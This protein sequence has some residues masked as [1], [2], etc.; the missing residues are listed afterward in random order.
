MVRKK[1]IML[2]ETNQDEHNGLATLLKTQTTVLPKEKAMMTSMTTMT[3]DLLMTRGT[4]MPKMVLM[5]LPQG[6]GAKATASRPEVG[7][8][9]HN[10]ADKVVA[11]PRKINMRRKRRR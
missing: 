1:T 10:V 3:V 11:W 4:R 5:L 6:N 9:G 2:V 8:L 7:G